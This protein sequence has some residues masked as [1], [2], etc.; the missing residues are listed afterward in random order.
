MAQFLRALAGLSEDPG[1]ILTIYTHGGSQP[2][3]ILVPGHLA[4]SSGLCGTKHVV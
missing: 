3:L 1:S 4:P 2:A